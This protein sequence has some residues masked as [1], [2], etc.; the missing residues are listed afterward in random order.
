MIF[1]AIGGFFGAISRF[2]ISNWIKQHFRTY[3]PLATFCINLIG[4]FLLGIC[5]GLGPI[6]SLQL[7]AGTGFLGAFTT[8]ST[9]SVESVKLYES[10]GLLAAATYMCLSCVLGILL[11]FIGWWLMSV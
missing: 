5:V 11:A 1:V 7:L 4:S 8:F 6:S 9:F 2:A 10:R 3:F